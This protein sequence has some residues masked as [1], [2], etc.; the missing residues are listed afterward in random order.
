M[1]V[2]EFGKQQSPRRPCAAFKRF[3]IT[4]IIHCGCGNTGAICILGFVQLHTNAMFSKFT[5]CHTS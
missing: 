1:E 3:I 4:S 2:R 5:F